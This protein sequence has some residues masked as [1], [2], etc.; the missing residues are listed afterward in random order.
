MFSQSIRPR[1]QHN[2]H[3]IKLRMKS[4]VSVWQRYEK[5]Q[6]I[7]RIIKKNVSKQCFLFHFFHY[8]AEKEYFCIAFENTLIK[9]QEKKALQDAFK[10]YKTKEYFKTK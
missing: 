7:P 5:K 4:I 8:V 10:T 9:W 3:N 1:P 6:Y 2:A